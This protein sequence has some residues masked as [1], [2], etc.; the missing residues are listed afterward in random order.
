MRVV[1]RVTIHT[2]DDV[3]CLRVTKTVPVFRLHDTSIL[4]LDP[5]QKGD[6]HENWVYRVRL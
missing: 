6:R 4:N 5:I 2:T 3:K 1:I